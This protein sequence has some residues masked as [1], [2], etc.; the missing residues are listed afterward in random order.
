MTIWGIFLSLVCMQPLAWAVYKDEVAVSQDEV[1]KAA[2]AAFKSYG[3]RKV[4]EKKMKI[5]TKWIY[6]TVTRSNPL[7][8]NVTKE[9]YE[10]RYR[11]KIQFRDRAGDTVVEVNGVFQQRPSGHGPQVSWT[12][13]KPRLEDLDIEQDDFM[14]I[15]SEM[16]RNCS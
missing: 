8:K 3:F 12:W 16:A 7:L 2:V 13:V 1:W 9:K 4:D 10:R 11:M 6:D 5:E 15:L 14:K